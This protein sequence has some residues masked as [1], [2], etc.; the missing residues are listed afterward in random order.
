MIKN[1]FKPEEK[2][3]KILA[4]LCIAALTFSC[5]CS[6]NVKPEEPE[7]APTDSTVVEE[8]VNLVEN[9]TGLDRQAMFIRYGENFKWF[10]TGVQLRDF[11]DEENDGTIDMIVNIFQVAEERE[12]GNFD[13]YVLKFQHFGEEVVED[14]VHGFWLDDFPLNEEDLVVT[15]NEAYEKVMEVNLPKPH[16]RQVVLRKELGPKPCNPQWIF[17]NLKSQIYV[18]AVTGEVRD[19]NPAYEGL[20]LGTPLGEWP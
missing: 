1:K 19:Y 18:D 6:N 11:L 7:V 15:F 14:A 13:T 16:T 20:N 4:F 2:M 12:T 5:K 8:P 9:A 10:E 17:G 3:R